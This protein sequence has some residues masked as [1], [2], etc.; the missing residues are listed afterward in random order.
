[1]ARG[2]GAVAAAGVVEEKIV[3]ECDVEKRLRLAVVCVGQLSVL[4]FK[5]LIR[6][7]KRNPNGIGTRGVCDCRRPLTTAVALLVFRHGCLS[8][9]RVCARTPPER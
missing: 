7:G 9:F 5:R 1:V 8:S 3:V 4:K 2:A 6:R